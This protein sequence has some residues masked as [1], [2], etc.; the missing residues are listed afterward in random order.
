[1]AQRVK[2]LP[3]VWETWVQSLGREDHLEKELATHS[4]TLAWKIPWTEDPD[5]IQ[6]M[7]SQRAG[8]DWATSLSLSV[9]HQAPST[10]DEISQWKFRTL[11]TKEKIFSKS[12]KISKALDFSTVLQEAWRYWWITPKFWKSTSNL[13]FHNHPRC[14]SI[15]KWE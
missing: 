15:R 1:M 11:S 12:K 3:A 6:S 2:R 4:S 7:G 9:F 13:E 10:M 5:R 14:Q 8:Q